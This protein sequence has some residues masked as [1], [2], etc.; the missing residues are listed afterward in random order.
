MGNL[1]RWGYLT[2]TEKEFLA[3]VKSPIVNPLRSHNDCQ[4]I[5]GLGTQEMVE[6]SAGANA[7]DP[8]F[9]FNNAKFSHLLQLDRVVNKEEDHENAIR[10]Q[11]ALPIIESLSEAFH[12]ICD[13]IIREDVKHASFAS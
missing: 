13:A 7:S 10:I 9:W 5:T 11:N 4:I 6:S 2:I 8:P 3:I 12:L 1:E